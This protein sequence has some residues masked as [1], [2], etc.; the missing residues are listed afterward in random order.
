MEKLNSTDVLFTMAGTD[1]SH[2]LI[3]SYWKRDLVR[4]PGQR[5]LVYCSV[6]L[7]KFPFWK[8]LKVGLKYIFGKPSSL[9]YFDEFVFTPEDGYK[10]KIISDYLM[11][12][13]IDDYMKKYP[14]LKLSEIKKKI[15]ED[16]G[17][18]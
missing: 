16:Y 17:A 5:P 10:L 1:I 2:Q 9:G 6:F 13:Q 7:N 12:I 14:E 11:N 8:R 15:K 4:K 18:E 3:F